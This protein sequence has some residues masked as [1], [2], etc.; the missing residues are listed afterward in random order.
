MRL[1]SKNPKP[2]AIVFVISLVAVTLVVIATTKTTITTDG[3]RVYEN[4]DLKFMVSVVPDE[5][6]DPTN[7][8]FWISTWPGG[9]KCIA[10]VNIPIAGRQVTFNILRWSWKG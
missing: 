4:T 7:Q 6:V 5:W 2:I 8:R 10:G 1:F 9:T 3:M